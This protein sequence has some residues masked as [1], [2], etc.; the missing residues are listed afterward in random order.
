MS[1]SNAIDSILQVAAQLAQEG[2]TF[3]TFWDFCEKVDLR[4]MNKR[5]L[6]S[7]IKSGALDSLRRVAQR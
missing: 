2:K 4:L 7:L 5:V 1:D 3:T 6:E